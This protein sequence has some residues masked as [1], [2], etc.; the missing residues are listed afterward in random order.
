MNVALVQHAKDDVDR[1]DRGNYQPARSF[2][3]DIEMRGRSL[4]FCVD[5]G[6][7]PICDLPQSMAFTAS[8]KDVRRQIERN[9]YRRELSLMVYR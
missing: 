5:A 8:P 7:I 3:S 4:E 2:D 6:R 1:D 9:R